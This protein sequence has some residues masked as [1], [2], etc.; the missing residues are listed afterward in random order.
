MIRIISLLKPKELKCIE[1]LSGIMFILIGSEWTWSY[2]IIQCI[3]ILDPSDARKR[4]SNNKFYPKIWHDFFF[5]IFGNLV[6]IFSISTSILSSLREIY[7]VYNQKEKIIASDFEPTRTCVRLIIKRKTACHYDPFQ[8]ERNRK[9]ILWVVFARTETGK[10][11]ICCPRDENNFRVNKKI[12]KMSI[13][14]IC[15]V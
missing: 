11:Y 6:N 2:L 3:S 5:L 4:S 8:F 1:L 10:I 12:C 15:N 13:C 14:K 7:Y 9:K